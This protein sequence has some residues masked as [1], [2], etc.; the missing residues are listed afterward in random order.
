MVA[1][2]LCA[3]LF[4]SEWGKKIDT[5]N[6]Q[7]ELVKLLLFCQEKSVIRKEETILNIKTAL[8]LLGENPQKLL[9]IGSKIM[10][11]IPEL[12][13]EVFG[14]EKAA[15]VADQYIH[16]EQETVLL[17][18]KAVYL[19]RYMCAT[20]KGCRAIWALPN[21]VPRL[22]QR[23]TCKDC[24]DLDSED[25]LT[26]LTAVCLSYPPAGVQLRDLADQSKV[27]QNILKHTSLRHVASQPKLEVWEDDT[28][29]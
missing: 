24:V 12:V 7:T 5:K 17:C 21:I 4:V 16:F 10:S 25:T 3:S 15:K 22:V 2:S 26:V 6:I 28:I 13:I 9:T 18:T 19:L 23:M 20:L 1:T 27:L 11:R 29:Y 8:A 14:E